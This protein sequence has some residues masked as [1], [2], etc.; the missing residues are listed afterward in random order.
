MCQLRLLL[1][2]VVEHFDPVGAEL[3]A[4]QVVDFQDG[5]QPWALAECLVSALVGARIEGVGD[6]QDQGARMDFHL[7]QAARIALAVSVFLVVQDNFGGI[8]PAFQAAQQVVA[9]AWVAADVLD[10]FAAEAAF[11]VQYVQWQEGHTQIVQAGSD[12]QLRGVD[13]AAARWL[14]ARGR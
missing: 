10:F 1:Q 3:A 8:L 6:R 14:M 12:S 9:K 7:A 5:A 11:L 13:H 4:R 2:G